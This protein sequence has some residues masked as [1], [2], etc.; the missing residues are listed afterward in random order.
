[1]SYYKADGGFLSS[2]YTDYRHT[3]DYQCNDGQLLSPGRPGWQ[4]VNVADLLSAAYVALIRAIELADG[5]LS[6]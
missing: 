5:R 3:G 2:I 6:A 4:G 1:M